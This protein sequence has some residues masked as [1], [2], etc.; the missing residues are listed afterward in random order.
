MTIVG[1]EGFGGREP[2]ML[3]SMMP[4]EG[5]WEVEAV[6]LEEGAEEALCMQQGWLLLAS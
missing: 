3:G 2:E 6:E 5:L 4:I 1:F